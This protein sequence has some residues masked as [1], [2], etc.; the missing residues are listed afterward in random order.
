MSSIRQRNPDRTAMR[1]TMAAVGLGLG[2]A[3]VG[4]TVGDIYRKPSIGAGGV[5]LG[6][7]VALLHMPWGEFMGKA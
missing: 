2:V 7:G 4:L 1:K 5:V 6:I 3:G